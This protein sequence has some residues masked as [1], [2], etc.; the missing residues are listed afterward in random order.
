MVRVHA[1]AIVE[2]CAF[3]PLAT[4]AQEIV[5]A[6]GSH[7]VVVSVRSHTTR[8]A[9]EI[10]DIDALE[11]TAAQ[12]G[13]EFA[14]WQEVRF[15]D[16]RVVAGPTVKPSGW[17][18]P[19]V[20]SQGELVFDHDNG[21]WGNP[22]DLETLKGAYTLQLARGLA[23]SHGMDCQIVNGELVIFQPGGQSIQVRADGSVEAVGFTGNGCADATRFLEE[24]L[25]K[26]LETDYKP[27]FY[28][29]AGAT[30]NFVQEWG[31]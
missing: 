21:R 7:S 25:G 11:R 19:I 26:P 22:A 9:V 14:F 13:W 18:Y 27:E 8:V 16:Q 3:N 17:Q 31:G 23:E 5:G 10:R 1:Y 20:A 28:G 12:L 6:L 15:Y 30:G 4:L 2:H 29:G 24:A